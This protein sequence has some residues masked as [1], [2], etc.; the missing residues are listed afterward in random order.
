MHTYVSSQY[1]EQ[2]RLNPEAVEPQSTPLITLASLNAD[3]ASLLLSVCEI[4]SNSP[5]QKKPEEM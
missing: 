3:F 4:L 1:I 5:N 2:P